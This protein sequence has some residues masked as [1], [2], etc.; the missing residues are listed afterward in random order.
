M[1]AK[2]E[3]SNEVWSVEGR[4]VYDGALLSIREGQRWTTW[5]AVLPT[6]GRHPTHSSPLWLLAHDET[7]VEDTQETTVEQLSGDQIL[8]D[9]LDVRWA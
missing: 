7:R 5:R 1:T 6:S 9:A 4:P 8:A 2:L 3:L